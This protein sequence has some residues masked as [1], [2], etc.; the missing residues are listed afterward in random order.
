MSGHNSLDEK[1]RKEAIRSIRTNLELLTDD[2]LYDFYEAFTKL[3]YD[4]QEESLTKKTWK[5]IDLVQKT[6]IPWFIH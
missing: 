1:Y 5:Q 2:E 6:C 3:M 4:L